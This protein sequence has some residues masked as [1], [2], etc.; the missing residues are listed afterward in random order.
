[1]WTR[2]IEDYSHWSDGCSLATRVFAKKTLED[3]VGDLSRVMLFSP[4][5]TALCMS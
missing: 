5:K 4:K 2:E 1:M 3:S